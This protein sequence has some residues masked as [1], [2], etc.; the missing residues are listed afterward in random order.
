[1]LELTQK[2]C[3]AFPQN[4]LPRYLMAEVCMERGDCTTAMEILEP[5]AN[6]DEYHRDVAYCQ[7]M[8]YHYLTRDKRRIWEGVMEGTQ[9]T[10]VSISID[11]RRVFTGGLDGRIVAREVA[12]HDETAAFVGHEGRIHSLAYC[13]DETLL[14]SGGADGV[15][16]IWG[17]LKGNCIHEFGG[18][19]G[20]VRK[21]VVSENGRFVLS[22][23]DDCI[24]RYW[25][26]RSGQCVQAFQGHG[27][28]VWDVALSRCGRYAFSGSADGTVIQWDIGT[29]KGLRRFSN[30][31]TKVWAIDV[32]PETRYVVAG[33]GSVL[34]V[35][36]IETGELVRNIQG[37]QHDIFGLSLC[38]NGRK[39]VTATQRGTVK[40][41]DI[42]SGQ[43]IRSL[44][45][46]A[47][48]QLSHDEKHMVSGGVQG[49]FNVWELF[50]DE[51][52]F[53][54]KPMICR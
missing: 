10:A 15:V 16:R 26:V 4:W 29:G 8:S 14:V 46:I 49:E 30:E 32:D 6:D 45:G 48:I 19:E 37:H 7:A 43:C 36:N 42:E 17:P 39:A 13:P 38:E 22:G 25:D 33:C 52:V 27:G 20:V 28:A 41:W 47:P 18:H 21:V 1:M 51:Q 40:I 53:T 24:V 54:A 34:Q 9:V 35:W 11:G 31:T 2:M 50:V 12:S 23:G 3:V 44:K 5:I